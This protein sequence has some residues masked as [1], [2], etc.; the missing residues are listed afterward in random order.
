[1]KGEIKKMEGGKEG[2]ME[3]G[4][5]GGTRAIQKQGHGRNKLKIFEKAIEK[6]YTY[7]YFI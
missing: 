3:R 4:K 5:E 6:Q 7:F 1:M 2:G